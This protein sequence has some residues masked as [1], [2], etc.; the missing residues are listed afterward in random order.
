MKNTLSTYDIAEL[1]LKDGYAGWSR[2]GA[3][4]LADYMSEWRCNDDELDVT[5][6]RCEWDEFESAI[7]WA[8]SYG[9]D[10]PEGATDEEWEDAALEEIRHNGILIEFD[11]GI[12]VSNF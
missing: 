12:I 6:I 7:E 1:L 2:N 4:A 11:G 3:N 10:R 8:E 5:E 9:F